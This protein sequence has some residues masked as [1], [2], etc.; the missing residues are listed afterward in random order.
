MRKDSIVL[1]G[2]AGV[3]K[4]TVGR[5]L[6]SALGHNFTDLDDYIEEKYGRTLQDIIDE[7]G[8]A[9]FLQREKQ[10]MYEIE[11]DRTVA[12]PGGSIIYHQDLMAYLRD[13][14]TLVFLDDSLANISERLDNQ[15]DRGIVGMKDKT[16]EQIFDERVGLYTQHAEV[17]VDCR[18][19]HPEEIVRE[20]LEELKKH[21]AR[22]TAGG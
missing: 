18:N 2:M 4:S 8:E 21:S 6:S 17:A 14:S 11:L 12:A 22:Q 16:L 20:I 9:A 10:C 5:Q 15:T 13:R 1:I 7:E 19:K 3:G